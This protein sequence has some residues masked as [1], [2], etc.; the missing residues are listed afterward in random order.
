MKAKW[1]LLSVLPVGAHAGVLTVSYEG[2]VYSADAG[3]GHEIGDTISGTLLIDTL[4]MG[5]DLALLDPNASLYGAADSNIPSID[6]VSGFATGVPSHDSISVRND[7]QHPG[8]LFDTYQI[9]DASAF[10]TP[11]FQHLVL[12][13]T[14]PAD[15]FDDDD[16]V[17]IFEAISQGLGDLGGTLSRGWDATRRQVDFHLSRLSVKPGRCVA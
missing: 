14:L 1:V 2:T 9:V 11:S 5:P 7:F 6:F 10:G 17:K 13:A 8:G 12:H 16:G 3:A 15:S 4:L